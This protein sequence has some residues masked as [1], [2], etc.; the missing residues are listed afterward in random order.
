MILAALVLSGCTSSSN[1][2]THEHEEEDFK[3]G[4][5]QGR[6]LEKDGFEVE[7]TIYEPEGA[8]P[9]FRIYFYDHGKS[10][11][12]AD[13]QFEMDLKRIN[14][15]ENIP[16]KQVGNFLESTVEAS[17][18]HSFQ[19]QIAARY[20]DRNFS[21][22][23]ETYEGRVE[24]TKEAI[25]NNHITIDV[26]GPMELQL[27]LNTMGKIIPNEDQ[28][29]YITPRFPG[30]VKA[31]YK[32][33]GDYV[34]KDEVLAEIESNESLQDYE[35][36]SPING[37]ITKKNINLG[38]SL[39]GQENVF[40]ISD[41]STV[42]ADFNLYRLDISQVQ[43]GNRVQVTSLDGRLKQQA[44]ISYISPLGNE[45]TQ[46]IIA[47][48]VL[49]NPDGKW[50][51]G[52]FISGEIALQ[53]IPVAVAVKDSALQTFRNWNV[54]FVSVGNLFEVAPVQLG[55]RNKEWVEI[56]SGLPSG[57]RYV[58]ENSYLLKADLEKSGAAHEH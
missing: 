29:I 51:P 13:I 9:K 14:R 49:E 43:V 31:V 1:E 34:A 24:L 21:W 11:N 50:K 57:S 30:M 47:R 41:L 55:R 8:P 52:L 54:V 48:A 3:R 4:A 37:M 53:T 38:M 17:E 44:V 28:T 20:K 45:S 19:V 39:S 56:T 2:H 32:K 46:S 15:T 27:T 40:V 6:V 7:V 5:H 16:F 36:R 26:A 33:L 35:M 25:E 22:N 23:Y 58:S 42:W 18:P 12:P 10:V